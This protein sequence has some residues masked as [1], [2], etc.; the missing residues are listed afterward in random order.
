L[1]LFELGSDREL[2]GAVALD[3]QR[4]QRFEAAEEFDHDL[5]IAGHLDGLTEDDLTA[6]DAD[7]FVR[8]SRFHFFGGDGA[9]ETAVFGDF[10][11]D[12]DADAFELA[13]V[14]RFAIPW[15]IRKLRA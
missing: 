5:V 4:D 9:V 11:L 1:G 8:E 13:S 2:G 6:V 14:A 12:L 7:L 3:L 10:L 15:G